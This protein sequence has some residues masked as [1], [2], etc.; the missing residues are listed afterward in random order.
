V[1]AAERAQLS[2][3]AQQ[4]A[5][6]H[7]GAIGLLCELSLFLRDTGERAD[8]LDAIEQCVRDFAT[9]TGGT[10]RRVLQRIEYSPP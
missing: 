9:I 7:A 4:R 8:Q 10:V 3:R 2:R 5:L 6:N 1:S